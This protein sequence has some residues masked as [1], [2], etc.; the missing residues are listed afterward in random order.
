MTDLV[1][2]RKNCVRGW[3]CSHSGSCASGSGK[4]ASR[5]KRLVGLCSVPRPRIGLSCC[6][7]LIAITI[8]AV[9]LKLSRR[10]N[11]LNL[12]QI[13]RATGIAVA[14]WI[15]RRRRRREKPPHKFGRDIEVLMTTLADH[16]GTSKHFH[17]T[18]NR[19][20]RRRVANMGV[21][22]RSLAGVLGAGLV[23]V[24]ITRRTLPG[25]I[26]SIAGGG[27]L[28]AMSATGY[29]PFYHA[30][31]IDNA[32]KGTAQPS[33]YY[34]EGVHVVV[35]Y[36][37][38][39]PAQELFQFWRNFQNLPKFMNHLKLVTCEGPTRSHWVAK[40]PAG[41]DV[42]WDAEIINE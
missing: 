29:C 30:L 27:V 4:T 6:T 25:M 35:S 8:A 36:L 9:R 10:S 18:I 11:L 1:E 3:I 21:I 19:Q 12:R 24:G 17:P 39:K 40:G 34:D 20:Q 26:A 13:I 15:D 41:I 32:R 14:S 16:L 33:D 22:D 28:L 37:I 2:S 5:S 7:P 23:G 31:S 42:E 38:A